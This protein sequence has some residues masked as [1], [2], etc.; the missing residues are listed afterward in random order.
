VLTVENLAVN[1]GP[2]EAV[3]GAGWEIG[4]GELVTLLGPNGAGKTSSLRAISQ[5]CSWAGDIRFEGRSLRGLAPERVVRMGI[6]HVPEGR[7]VFPTL[8]VIENVQIGR[9]ARRRRSGF[10][11]DDVLE[12]MP[13]LKPLKDRKGWALSGGEQQMVAIGRALVGAPRLLLLDEPS[14]GLAPV[15]ASTVF[16]AL[17]EIAKHTAILV[18]EQNTALAL[19]NCTRGY[20]MVD[21]QIVM[22]GASAELQDRQAMLDAFLGERDDLFAGSEAGGTEAGGTEA[23]GARL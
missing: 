12:L 19:K 13:L 3:R 7:R 14:L 16:A 11:V 1:Y 6:V 21:G 17:T 2:V 8:T 18:V 20:V 5:L 10:T 23:G 4:E 22:S 15:V 9:H